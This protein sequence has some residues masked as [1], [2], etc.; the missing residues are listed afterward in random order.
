MNCTAPPAP[1]CPSRSCRTTASH[2]LS[3]WLSAPPPAQFT[4]GTADV[5]PACQESDGAFGIPTAATALH[6]LARGAALPYP[7]APRSALHAPRPRPASVCAE[8]KGRGRGGWAGWEG[9]GASVDYARYE[10]RMRR[11]G[12]TE[13]CADWGAHPVDCIR[14]A[15][16]ARRA[17][18]P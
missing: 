8:T 2:R 13:P 5:A 18:P 4:A 11:G 7:Y 12:E 10:G 15:R 14:E 16:R 9:A 1:P 17:R 6:G 3:R